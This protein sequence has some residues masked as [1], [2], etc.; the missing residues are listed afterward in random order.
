[1]THEHEYEH[2]HYDEL[3]NEIIEEHRHSLYKAD[4]RELRSVGIDIGSTTSHLIFSRLVL[5]RQS[6]A[7]S[8]RFEVA[9]RRVDY[10]SPIMITPFAGGTSI[11]T[12]HL[13]AFFERAYAESGTRPE[14]VDTGAVITTGDAARKDNA[15]AIVR[16]FSER[17]GHF[18]CASAGPVLEARMA[19]YGSGAIMRSLHGGETP[20]VLNIDVGGGTSKLAVVRGG[21]IDAV[22]A[23][24]VGARLI[25]LDEDGVVTKIEAAAAICSRHRGLGLRCG[26]RAEESSL[27][28]LA[29][30]LAES[31]LE[32][33]VGG[34]L[35]PL[36]SELMITAPFAERGPV[37]VVFFSGGVSEYFYRETSE[38][39]GD[40]GARLADAIRKRSEAALPG[41]RIELSRE[42][43]RATVIGASQF[44]VQLSGN[45]IYVANA[46]LLPL[47]NLRVVG[48][49]LA[50]VELRAGTIREAI[51]ESFARVGVEAG[52]ESVALA[53]RWPHGPA[54]AHLKALC[55]GV[56]EALSQ[57]VRKGHPVVL[58]LDADVSRLVGE[59][60]SRALDRYRDIICIDGVQ[61]Q[62]LD[63]IDISREHEHTRTVSV[64]IKSLVFTG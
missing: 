24:N 15:E 5:R 12:R 2:V 14:E 62:D 18:V 10:A 48:V 9:E 25:T 58:V 29:D 64:V 60:L 63:Y 36:S 11:D 44:T 16:L 46:K 1:M 21:R 45:T 26:V 57:N 33:A 42:R 49:D 34:P 47:R 61:L 40:I 43:I 37:D 56:A 3:G 51:E 31:L 6:A 59:N 54:Y 28:G 32:V 38:S 23:I 39:Y 4:R 27:A 17:A 50:R 35:S 30:A 53:L 22:A 52:E 41:T 8:S 20:S 7:L 55:D 19:A 13:S